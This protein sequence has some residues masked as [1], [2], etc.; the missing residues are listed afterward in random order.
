M[1][2]LSMRVGY[3]SGIVFR[4]FMELPLYILPIFP[5]FGN[6]IDSVLRISIPVIIF[7]WLYQKIEK[8][9]LKKIVIIEKKKIIKIP[10]CKAALYRYIS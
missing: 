7:L 5:N 2:Y 3:K 10:S 1:T 4:F 8:S 6:Y 9:K